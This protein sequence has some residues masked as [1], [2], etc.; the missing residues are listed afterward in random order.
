MRAL[1]S[2]NPHRPLRVAA[3]GLAAT[4]ALAVAATTSS[5]ALLAAGDIGF[6]GPSFTSLSSTIP[7]PTAPTSEKPQSKL[8]FHD[9]LWWAVMYDPA[10]SFYRIFKL[11]PTTNAWVATSAAVD[12]RENIGNDAKWDGQR[13]YVLSHARAT[14]ATGAAYVRRYTYDAATKEYTRVATTQIHAGG[15]NAMVLDKDTTGVLWATWTSAG[16][17]FVT[18]TTTDD[19]T[20]RAAY[21]L[22][23]PEAT[24]LSTAMP[25]IASVVAYG[26]KIGIMWS[27]QNRWAYRFASHVDGAP[28][29]AW[30]VTT[31]LRSPEISDDHMNIKAIE[32]DPSGSVFA[33]VKTSLNAPDEPMMILLVLRPNGTWAQ[34]TVFNVVD[35]HT[36]P[37]VLINQEARRVH[38]FATAPCCVGGNVYVK[39]ANLDDIAFKDGIGTP[40]I[41][42]S[43]DPNVNNPSST[44]QPVTLA[45]GAVVLGADDR[46]DRYAWNRL[47]GTED[48]SLAPFSDGFESGRFQGWKVTAKKGADA[49]VQTALVKTGTHAARITATRD[50]AF[51]RRNIGTTVKTVTAAADVQMVQ[52]GSA[53]VTVLELEGEKDGGVALQRASNGQLKL[54]IG[55]STVSTAASLPAGTW[56]RLS[57][58]IVNAGSNASVEVRMDGTVIHSGTGSTRGIK[59]V[60]LGNEGKAAFD[61]VVDDVLITP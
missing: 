17:V 31:P 34:H 40:F 54:R 16:K 10:T 44:K 55:S 25:E 3:D 32:G 38:V 9:G 14:S 48:P 28:D 8:W 46:T 4:L 23:V 22:P 5:G 47:T 24:G 27:D 19:A 29:T 42:L 57:V 58:R 12:T 21:V 52:Q 13:L 39:T 30:T 33:A 2:L 35:Q 11:D 26:G 59:A 15:A 60:T 1:V 61:A 18:H 56:A 7:T 53:T 43:T 49:E 36:R 20:W 51:I 50:S 6:R 45:S 41:R 37:L